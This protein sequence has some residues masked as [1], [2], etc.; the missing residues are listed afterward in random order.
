MCA[1]TITGVRWFSNLLAPPRH[2]A[3]LCQRHPAPV[4]FVCDW[5]LG[6]GL[7]E[8]GWAPT[9]V[10]WCCFASSPPLRVWKVMHARSQMR[11]SLYLLYS[12]IWCS[13]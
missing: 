6:K 7:H 9:P 10:H 1:C 11:C 13:L 12:R 8:V 4:D 2:V 5:V 3:A